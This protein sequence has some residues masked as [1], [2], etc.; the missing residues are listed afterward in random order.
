MQAAYIKTKEVRQMVTWLRAGS[1]PLLM[2]D[3][4]RNGAA[5]K[6]ASLATQLR[7]RLQLV[8]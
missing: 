1:R 7:A 6:M 2:A 4:G 8:K 3:T 5:D